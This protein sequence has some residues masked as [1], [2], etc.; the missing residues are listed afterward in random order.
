MERFI[1]ADAAAFS[2][3]WTGF[4]Q[5]G[6]VVWFSRGLIS[7][8][9][10]KHPIIEQIKCEYNYL[11]KNDKRLDSRL[12]YLRSKITSLDLRAFRTLN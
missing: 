10:P 11:I 8:Y 3:T 7:N 6:S 2:G 1:N 4:E 5:I 9:Q 12:T